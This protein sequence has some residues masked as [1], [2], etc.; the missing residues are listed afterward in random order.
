MDASGRKVVIP[1]YPQRII[2]LFAT[3]NDTLF[4]I[5]AGPQIVAVDDFTQWPK[6]P[7]AKPSVGGNNFKFDVERMVALKPDLVITSFGTEEIVDKPLRDAGVKV[8][9]MPFPTSIEQTYQLMRDLGR[10]TYHEAAAEVEVIRLEETVNAVQSVSEDVQTQTVYF[11]TDASVPGKPYTISPG[12]LIE[13]MITL[14]GGRNVFSDVKFGSAGPQVGYEAI[15]RANPQVIILANVK[16]SVGRYFV[17]PVTLAEVRQRPGFATIGA[18]RN[19]RLIA[20]DPALT[21]PGPRL[22]DGLR[23]ISAAIHPLQG[24]R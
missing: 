6:G 13:E 2:S 16:G 20:I 21:N 24:Q 3:N 19:R 18:V 10:I 4:T 7:V 14:A 17:N 8:V 5:G 1:K 9:T 12:S 23:A 15:V 11:E 22:R